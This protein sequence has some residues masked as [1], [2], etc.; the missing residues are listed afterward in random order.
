[1]MRRLLKKCS[2][3]VLCVAILFIAA[4][5]SHAIDHDHSAEIV[6]GHVEC[7]HCIDEQFALVGSSK[8]SA[9]PQR[10]ALFHTI[11]WLGYSPV[12]SYSCQA[13]APPVS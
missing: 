8:L 3:L 12:A 5:V 1:M 2:R 6:E 11:Q 13:R 7:V 4:N 9:L 10:A